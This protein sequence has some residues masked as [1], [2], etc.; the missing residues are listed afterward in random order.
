M[1][2]RSPLRIAWTVTWLIGL[3][4]LLWWFVLPVSMGGR[5]SLVVAQ[6]VSMQPRLHAGDLIIVRK[7]DNSQLQVGDVVLYPSHSLHRYVLHRIHKV[8]ADGRFTMKGDNNDFLDPDHPTRESIIGKKS[9]SVAGAGKVPGAGSPAVAGLAVATLLFLVFSKLV[10]RGSGGGTPGAA[11]GAAAAAPERR[12]RSAQ[13]RARR[14]EPAARIGSFVVTSQPRLIAAGIVVL[15]VLGASMLGIAKSRSLPMSNRDVLA[16]AAQKDANKEEFR[17]VGEF[18]YTGREPSAAI[19]RDHTVSTGDAVFTKSATRIDVTFDYQLEGSTAEKV[20]GTAVLDIKIADDNGWSSIQT[21]DKTT[22]NAGHATLTAQ[23]NFPALREQLRAFER[24]SK[25]IPPLY[26][27]TLMPKVTLDHAVPAPIAGS[28]FDPELPMVLDGVR[29]RP[30]QIAGGDAAK[31][32]K[33][34]E[35]LENTVVSA[36]G[37]GTDVGTKRVTRP[38]AFGLI[39]LGLILGLGLAAAIGYS[40]VELARNDDDEDDDGFI[41][42]DVRSDEHAVDAPP[43]RVA[44]VV[45]RERTRPAAPEPARPP[46]HAPE[47]VPNPAHVVEPAASAHPDDMPTRR[48]PALGGPARR[49]NLADFPSQAAPS[50]IDVTPFPTAAPAAPTPEPA[51]RRRS[52]ELHAMTPPELTPRELLTR[53][54]I[55]YLPTSIMVFDDLP[56]FDLHDPEELVSL[57]RISDRPVS[58]Y[59]RGDIEHW[60]VRTE[61]AYYVLTAPAADADGETL[62]WAA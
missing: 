47:P 52:L 7:T 18:S 56:R 37:L 61:Y 62:G 55:F 15:L 60:I 36:D 13:R 3:A 10:L 51:V 29:L 59:G 35:V 33:P 26:H 42:E 34:T 21:L 16:K 49:V 20:G 12:S 40:S 43:L 6:G 19:Q 24:A 11:A 4:L 31:Q 9:F 22:V 14:T 27:L 38:V 28:V 23:V 5:T 46:L 2:T 30:E 8:D 1:V 32:Y 44:P 41:R 45:V 58:L 48:M 53:E 50:P 39:A 54:G 25:T 57:A 17:H